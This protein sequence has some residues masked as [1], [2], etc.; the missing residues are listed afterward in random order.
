MV[1]WKADDTFAIGD[2]EYVCRPLTGRFPSA[3]DRFCLLKARWQVEWYEQLLQDLA[4]R[5]MIEVGTY[6]GGSVALCAQ[7]A[8]V[9][10][11]VGL[12]NR[13][14]RSAALDTFIDRHHFQE[15]VRP[16]YR[17]DQADTRRLNEIVVAEFHGRPVDL[18]V[19]DASHLY[20]QTRTTFNC[21][22]PRVRPGG[23]YVIEDW[24]MH[25][26]GPIDTPLTL[27]VFELLL[28]CASAPQVIADV[29]VNRNYA[30]ISRGEAELAAEFDLAQCY[31]PRA[32]ALIVRPESN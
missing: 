5:T 11:L 2:I 30:V 6:D 26:K 29:Y 17:V 14:M 16:H 10:T 8:L 13:D 18:V 23:T 28:A 9:D 4:P 27:L 19:D 12:A 20:D 24:P 15:R 1:A 7:L 25:R 31:G 32:A 22:Y 21:L 3:P